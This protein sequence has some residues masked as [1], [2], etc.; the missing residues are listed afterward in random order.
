LSI[1]LSKAEIG[2]RGGE[3]NL[4]LGIE[5]PEWVTGEGKLDGGMQDATPPGRPNPYELN[6]DAWPVVPSLHNPNSECSKSC[7][8]AGINCSPELA[9]Q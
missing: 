8:V 3:N 6:V 1:R 5:E 9:Q 4:H 2:L 7:P